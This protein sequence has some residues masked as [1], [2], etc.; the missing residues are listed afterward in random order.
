MAIHSQIVNMEFYVTNNS[1]TN[2]I[3]DNKIDNV[4]Y[5][6]VATYESV[7]NVFHSNIITDAKV[8]VAA[9]DESSIGNAFKNDKKLVSFDTLENNNIK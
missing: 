6:L 7:K 1:F 9:Q 8:E 4:E 2:E 5:G 3:Y